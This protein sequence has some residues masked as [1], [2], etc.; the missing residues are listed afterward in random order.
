MT[1]NYVEGAYVRLKDGGPDML[2][3]GIFRQGWVVCT[4]FVDGEKKASVFQAARL[5]RLVKK[6][7]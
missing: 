1:E 7:A 5:E 3:E 2:V 6:A 4:W